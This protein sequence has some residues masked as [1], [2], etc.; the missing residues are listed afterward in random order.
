MDLVFNPIILS[1]VVLCV[2]C[3]VK[4]NVLLALIFAA[5]TAGLS[6]G[7]DIGR[8]MTLLADGFSAN[9]TTALSYILLG[10]FAVAIADTG[11]MQ[12]LVSWLSKHLGSRRMIFC[13]VLA[14][15]ACLSQNVVPVH[16]AFIPLL[17]PPL[18]S[19]M[20][21][22]QLDRRAAACALSFGLE[23]PYIT[24]PIGFGLIFQGIVADSM[25]RSG[26]PTTV[27]DVASVNW[28][29][30]ASM[31]VGLLIAIFVFYRKPRQ[32]HSKTIA[33]L[34]DSSVPTR[35]VRADCSG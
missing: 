7:L 28:I 21:K 26:M 6:G 12:M 2:L 34:S 27:S 19:L 3:L 14:F 31:L 22:M 23:A 25:T 30:G 35:F 24:L 10:T 9:A 11:L 8:T 32:Y 20:N 15:I 16:I 29:L 1:V 13:L 4:V 17:I 18:L 5:I 33:E